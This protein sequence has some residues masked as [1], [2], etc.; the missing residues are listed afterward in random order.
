[1][2]LKNQLLHGA[3]PVPDSYFTA[4]S[5]WSSTYVAYK[6]RLDGANS[7]WSP[8]SA[9]RDAIPPTFYLQ[10]SQNRVL[11]RVLRVL[12]LVKKLLAIISILRFSEEYF[13][14]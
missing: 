5:E 9:E 11:N 4:S 12:F 2:L 7:Y 14:Y 6:A 3:S 10:V 8:T 1:V 13:I